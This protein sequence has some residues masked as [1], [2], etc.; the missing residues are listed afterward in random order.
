MGKLLNNRYIA[1][2]SECITFL[3]GELP[4]LKGRIE[5]MGEDKMKG[6]IDKE[7]SIIK[8]D[9]TNHRDEIFN[10][11]SSILSEKYLYYIYIYILYRVE[12]QLGF[13]EKQDWGNVSYIEERVSDYMNVLLSVMQQMH[14]VLLQI[15]SKNDLQKVFAQVNS[16]LLSGLHSMSTT[17]KITNQSGAKQY[18]TTNYI[19][20]YIYNRLKDDLV[21][22]MDTLEHLVTAETQTSLEVIKLIREV[23][24]V[25]CVPHIGTDITRLQITK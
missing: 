4:Y 7:L 16:L 6:W 24:N 17:I 9:F 5:L 3:L 8:R 20:I 25:H 1:L 14:K 15:L 18:L 12:E 11:L 23:Y 13:G 2:S 10:K 19:Y 21:I 22:L